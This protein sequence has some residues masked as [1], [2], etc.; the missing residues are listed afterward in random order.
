MTTLHHLGRT[1]GRPKNLR[2]LLQSQGHLRNLAASRREFVCGRTGLGEW[3]NESPGGGLTELYV[4]HDGSAGDGTQLP[5]SLGLFVQLDQRFTLPGHVGLSK[6][7]E[8]A[9]GE[10][11]TA[12]EREAAA[13]A[14]NR[15]HRSDLLARPT[16]RENQSQVLYTAHDFIHHTPDSEQFVC[17]G[18]LPSFPVLRGMHNLSCEMHE[19]PLLLRKELKALFPGR[20]VEQ[21]NLSL[22]TIAQRTQSDMSAW[23]EDMEEEREKLTEQFFTAAKEI[24]ARWDQFKKLRVYIREG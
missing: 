2:L 9:F 24:C 5:L 15:S 4:Y 10:A 17:S 3:R 8:V 7:A 21:G 1:C 12:E 19:A 16:N 23:S 11:Y 18:M 13:K 14:E 6:E 20:D 22:I